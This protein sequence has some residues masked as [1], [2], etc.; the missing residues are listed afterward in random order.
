[1]NCGEA[2]AVLRSHWPEFV[3]EALREGALFIVYLA[4]RLGPRARSRARAELSARSHESYEAA[5]LDLAT[6]SP[7]TLR[8]GQRGCPLCCS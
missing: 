1:M 3:G 8:C 5:V 7:P 4:P 6:W 2:E